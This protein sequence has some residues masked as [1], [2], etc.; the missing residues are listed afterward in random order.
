MCNI[1]GCEEPVT[2]TTEGFIVPIGLCCEHA[3]QRLDNV[4]AQVGILSRE[5]EDHGLT[6]YGQELAM[7]GIHLK[8]E[9]YLSPKEKEEP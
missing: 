1:D 2:H 7:R 4:E 8:A 6:F 5:L 9:N 3:Q